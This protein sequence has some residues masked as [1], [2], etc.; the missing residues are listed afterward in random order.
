MTM[1]LGGMMMRLAATDYMAQPRP[2]TSEGARRAMA[3]VY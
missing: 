2:P 3:P 1:K